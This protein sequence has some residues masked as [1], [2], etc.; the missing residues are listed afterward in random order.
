M[1][2]PFRKPEVRLLRQTTTG[3]IFSVKSGK[4]FL[5]QCVV[6]D[7][8]T[9]ASIHSLSWQ[10]IPLIRFWSKASCPT[11]AEFVYSGFAADEQGV[12]QFLS[13]IENW[14]RPWSDMMD[15]FT[16][17]TPLFSCL[18]D[19]YYLLEDREL[20]PTD[21]NGHFFWAATDHR[22]SNPATVAIWDHEYGYYSDTAPCFLLPGQPPS[23]FNP[24]RA[25][26]YRDKPDIRALAWYLTDSYLCVML[27]GH[28]KATAAA[29]EGRP[30]KTLV[31]S[32]ATHFNEEQQKLLF[33][34]GEFL[35]KTEL[36][37][38]VPKITPWN[39]L[40]ASAWESFGPDQHVCIYE[41]WSKE[42][43]QSVSR[44][45]SL[46]QA[47]QIAEAGNL[48]EANIAR[49]INEGLTGDEL[50]EVILQALFY[51]NY[52]LFINFARFITH[53]PTYARH[54]HITFRLMA[55]NRTPQADAFFLD[56]AINDDGERPELTKIMDDYYRQP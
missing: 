46:N 13:A 1:I 22:S 23:H 21:G 7:P 39:K 40:P 17:L 33:P 42:L 49:M 16:A 19:G 43:T 31:I 20:Y 44:Y 25:T 26:W 51:H 15:A 5:R 47:W 10:D 50:P 34:G 53:E 3:V 18:A 45:P 41:N 35:Q 8:H 29:L 30:L 55:Q 27:D 11:C 6:N 37:W 38:R 24:E 32:T 54:R 9:D 4:G 14:N 28:H 56:F 48:S 52:T 36:Q 2:F 12:A